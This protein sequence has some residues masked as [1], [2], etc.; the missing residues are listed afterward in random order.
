MII[1]LVTVVLLFLPQKWIARWTQILLV[2][3]ACEWLRASWT[4]VSVRQEF[5]Q[6][7]T[8]L[9]IILGGVALFTLLSA[10]SFQSSTL[11]RRYRLG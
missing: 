6:P 3:G 11:R 9:A 10:L 8:R 5:D 4:Y 7:W 1:P 2:L